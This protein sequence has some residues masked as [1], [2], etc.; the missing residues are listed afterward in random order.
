L[1]RNLKRPS[2]MIPILFLTSRRPPPASREKLMA[3]GAL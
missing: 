3:A 1:K 2:N